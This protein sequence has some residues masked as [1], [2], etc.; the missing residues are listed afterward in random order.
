MPL[1]T[2]PKTIEIDMSGR[3]LTETLRT[4]LQASWL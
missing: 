4:R 2:K 3:K 1:E